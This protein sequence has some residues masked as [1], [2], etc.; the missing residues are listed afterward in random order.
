MGATHR[1]GPRGDRSVE[2]GCS[3]TVVP[4][5]SVRAAQVSL[6]RRH[7]ADTNTPCWQRRMLSRSSCRTESPGSAAQQEQTTTVNGRSV[8]RRQDVTALPSGKAA[9]LPRARF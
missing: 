9:A 7:G 5:P 2:Q 8:A 4:G 1:G 6:P 3:N